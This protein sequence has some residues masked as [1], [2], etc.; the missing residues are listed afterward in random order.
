MVKLGV[1]L[2]VVAGMIGVILLFFALDTRTLSEKYIKNIVIVPSEKIEPN[3]VYLVAN[4]NLQKG[5]ILLSSLPSS[6]NVSQSAQSQ[7]TLQ[8]VHQQLRQR[9]ANGQE[10]RAAYTKALGLLVDEVWESSAPELFT[11]KTVG[12]AAWVMATQ[13]A[14]VHN[15]WTLGDIWWFWWHQRELRS[16]K[17]QME[18]ITNVAQFQK[19]V[20]DGE[21]LPNAN[22]CSITILNASQRGGVASELAEILKA[23][24]LAV[25]RTDQGAKKQ[26]KTQIIIDKT[27]QPDCQ[28][29]ANRIQ[30]ALPV[31]AETSVRM[32]AFQMYRSSIVVILG[33]EE[34]S[35]IY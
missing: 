20:S 4:I 3:S 29:V 14:K 13:P 19:W 17:V 7:T 6:L 33:E 32:D 1:L 2:A 26:P 35:Q 5:Y 30:G 28:Q 31:A 16:S 11:A 15:S 24:Q 9:N 18:Q 34:G 10:A 23:N 27:V 21:P 25:I 22:T 8:A 12:Q